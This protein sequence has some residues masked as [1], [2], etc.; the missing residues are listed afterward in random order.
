M[1][2]FLAIAAL[3]A[4]ILAASI[5]APASAFADTTILSPKAPAS[6]AE[7]AAYVQKLDLAIKREC[8]RATAPVIGVAYFS[9]RH[10]LKDTRADVA[11]KD[12]TGLYARRDS[13][14]DI[15]VAAK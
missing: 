10:C 9:Y 2:R 6:A 14:S 1:K 12:P 5:L 7:A 4:S 8:Q 15:V 13:V 11:K 3:P